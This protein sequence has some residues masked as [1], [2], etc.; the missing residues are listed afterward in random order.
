V[1]DVACG[2]GI[3]AR[4]AREQVGPRGRVVAVDVSAPMLQVARDLAP[5]VDW[6]EAD[7]SALPLHEDEAFDVIFCQ[8][9]LQFFSDR[10][11]AARE[12]RRGVAPGGRIAVSTWRPIDEAPV[13]RETHRIAERHLGPTVDQRH[14]LG[15]E[16]ALARLLVEAGFDDVRCRKVALAIRF[17]DATPFVR[18]N[19]MALV[20]MS[21]AARRMGE[22]EREEAVD[23]IARESLEAIAG[24]ARGGELAFD[25]VANVA[26]ASSPADA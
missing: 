19:A 20:G 13:F 7:A 3:V 18:M 10:T 5:D 4:L 11:A 12:M 26:T 14:A 21:D 24:Y 16:G 15:D 17:A 25:T 23:S 9:G 2:T 22:A 6:R 1:L 8:Q